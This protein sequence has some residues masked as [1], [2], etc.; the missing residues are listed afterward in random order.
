MDQIFTTHPKIKRAAIWLKQSPQDASRWVVLGRLLEE[1][2]EIELAKNSYQRALTLQPDDIEV[3]SALASLNGE[4]DS[5]PDTPTEWLAESI[6][7]LRQIEVPSWFQVFLSFFSFTVTL[8]IARLEQWDAGELVWSLWISG[9]IIG[10][11]TLLTS[12]SGSLSGLQAPIDQKGRPIPK[13]LRAIGSLYTLGFFSVHFGIFNLVISIF[14]WQFFPIFSHLPQNPMNSL[15][16]FFLSSRGL[17]Q[18]CVLAFWPIILLSILTNLA[19]YRKALYK[20]VN[21]SMGLPYVNVIRMHLSIFVLSFLQGMGLSNYALYYFLILY[22]FPWSALA[23]MLRGKKSGPL[24]VR[25]TAGQSGT[26]NR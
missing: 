17:I 13:A 26:A 19:N 12:I 10:Y 8:M 5:A 14:L 22:Y 21:E 4:L 6:S 16:S 15:F 24:S 18:S 20:P 3:Q 23:K 11:S 7:E 25:G 9:A 2:G 1:A